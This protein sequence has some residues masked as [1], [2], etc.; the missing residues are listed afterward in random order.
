L[1]L[2]LN[3]FSLFSD[4]FDF[5]VFER[6]MVRTI[7]TFFRF[8]D[9]QEMGGVRLKDLKTHTNSIGGLWGEDSWAALVKESCDGELLDATGGDSSQI[10]E[11]SQAKRALLIPISV[12]SSS[13]IMRIATCLGQSDDFRK[14]GVDGE[15]PSG[16]EDVRNST[17][18]SGSSL[19][20]MLTD[21]SRIQ[22]PPVI[23]EEDEGRNDS[24]NQE[25]ESH[26]CYK[27]FHV[28]VKW[29]IETLLFMTWINLSL[30]LDK[31]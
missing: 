16:V 9:F 29:L 19:N 12:F 31:L 27:L 13:L 15:M 11:D 6:I 21:V 17:Q 25:S 7:F 1:A 24:M 8:V 22:P 4:F 23:V 3:G 2:G 26:Q 20:L 5:T 14:F 30:F 10:L 28:F 18:R